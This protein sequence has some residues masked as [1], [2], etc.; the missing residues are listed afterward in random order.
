[1]YLQAE[2]SVLKNVEDCLDSCMKYKLNIYEVTLIPCRYNSFGLLAEAAS[3]KST[4]G[5]RDGD[6]HG[7]SA[8]DGS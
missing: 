7:N 2:I 3:K 4:A 5:T 8:G 6:R 1:M